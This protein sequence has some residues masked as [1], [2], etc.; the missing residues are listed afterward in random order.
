MK[1]LITFLFLGA[2]K[3][4]EKVTNYS[5]IVANGEME[6]ELTA[7]PLVP[8]PIGKRSTAYVEAMSMMT[9]GQKTSLKIL[10]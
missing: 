2:C 10:L 7:P 9:I 8:K 5:D 6:A 3:K 1:N 4:E